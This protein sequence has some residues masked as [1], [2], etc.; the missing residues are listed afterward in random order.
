MARNVVK[1][2]TCDHG[3]SIDWAFKSVRSDG[4]SIISVGD[5]TSGVESCFSRIVGVLN[6]FRLISWIL[7]RCRTCRASDSFLIR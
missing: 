5:E 2:A 3:P 4:Q 7:H 1:R 6:D